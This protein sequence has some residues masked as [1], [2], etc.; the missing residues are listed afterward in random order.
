ME[1]SFRASILGL[2]CSDMVSIRQHVSDVL[3]DGGTV[4]WV[5]ATQDDI[6]FLII[7]SSFISSSSIQGLLRKGA[8][9]LLVNRAT[10]GTDL[11]ENVLPLPLENSRL[12]TWVH[13]YVLGKKRAATSQ[14]ILQNSDLN[15]ISMENAKHFKSLTNKA[16]GLIYLSDNRGAIGVVDTAR[17]IICLVPGRKTSVDM[18]SEVK[19][20]PI[21]Q[22]PKLQPPISLF[23]WM[24]EVLWST[25]SSAMLIA[26]DQPVKLTMWPQPS[27]T[28]DRKD[29]LRMSAWLAKGP[30]NAQTLATMS[31]IPPH[32]AQHFLST[33]VAM[34]FGETVAAVIA[35]PVPPPIEAASPQPK[36]EQSGIRRLLSGLRSRLGL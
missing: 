12:Q 13:E 16:N 20:E 15:R 25:P 27:R 17:E 8:P 21:Q 30:A 7:N 23:H 9:V 19:Y 26:M 28:A 32:R 10:A 29:V 6:D 34:G 2:G 22:M 31:Q 1:R 18:V 5:P 11:E 3:A 14:M 35:A 24:W 36:P 33:L 4:N